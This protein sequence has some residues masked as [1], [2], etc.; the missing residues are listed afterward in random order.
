MRHFLSKV[1]SPGMTEVWAVPPVTTCSLSGQFVPN[2]CPP[3][4]SLS[5]LR[6]VALPSEG[7]EGPSN[8]FLS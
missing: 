8:L 5:R 2:R 7:G 4:T 1:Q 6:K 3:A